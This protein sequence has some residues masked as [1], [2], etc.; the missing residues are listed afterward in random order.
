MH[1]KKMRLILSVVSLLA[2][3]LLISCNKRDPTPENRDPLFL[4]LDARRRQTDQDLA[5]AR[6]AYEEAQSKLLDVA[7]QTGQIKYAQKRIADT[8]ERITKLEQLLKYYEIK[9]ESQRWRAREAYLLAEF[10]NKPWPNQQEREDFL[11]S[12]RAESSPH[13]WSVS[14]RRAS[15][16]LPNGHT[17][18]KAP[19]IESHSESGEH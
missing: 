1:Q 11:E 12:L 8:E 15:L 19:K 6:A 9:Y 18:N 16:G 10:D 3:G 7:P 5:A 17:V 2:A 4:E 14:D 13:T